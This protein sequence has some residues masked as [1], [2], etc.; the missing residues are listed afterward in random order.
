[1]PSIHQTL[2]S[3][4]IQ[5]CAWKWAG[6]K[7]RRV[8]APTAQADSACFLQGAGAVLRGRNDRADQWMLDSWTEGKSVQID[9]EF[10]ALTSKIALKTLLDLDDPGD[11]ERFSDTLRI[12]FDL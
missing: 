2:R 9:R 3:T 10:E 4:S 12:A 5:T 6:Y 1:M 8:L 7:R 11:R